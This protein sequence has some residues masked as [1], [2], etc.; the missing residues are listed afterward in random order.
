MSTILQGKAVTISGDHLNADRAM[1]WYL[2][3]DALPPEEIAQ[4]FMAGIDPSIISVVEKGDILVCGRNFGF[5]KVHNAFFASLTVLEIKCIVAE[6]FSTQLFQSAM[7]QGVLLV[8]CPNVLE[9]VDMRDELEVDI[10]TAT[11]KNLSQGVTLQGEPLPE[12]C[13]DVLMS[14]GHVGY[15][16]RSLAAKRQSE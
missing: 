14:G 4:K 3:M 8:A 15:L 1:G 11:V 12:Y 2:G 7:M 9:Q 5:G 13:L 16:M 10:K 6:S